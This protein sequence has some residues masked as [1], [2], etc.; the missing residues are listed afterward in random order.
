V[1]NTSEIGDINMKYKNTT[2]TL[3]YLK[4]SQRIDTREPLANSHFSLYSSYY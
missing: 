3:T 1:S 2:L 4:A